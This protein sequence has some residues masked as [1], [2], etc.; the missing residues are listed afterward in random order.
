MTRV[1]VLILFLF[2]TACTTTS[3]DKYSPDGKKIFSASNT[4]IG[5][6]RENITLDLKKKDQE[7]D[8]MIGI[9]SS[10]GSSGLARAI[11]AMEKTLEELKG[12]RP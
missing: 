8:L 7:T 6:D 12:L 9:G 11:T 10:S 4:S 3:V 2:L 1:M 5:W